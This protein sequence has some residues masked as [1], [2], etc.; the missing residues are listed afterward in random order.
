MGGGGGHNKKEEAMEGKKEAHLKGGRASG[1]SRRRRRRRTRTR[2]RRKTIEREG[3]E[4]HESL[5]SIS[6]TF[7]SV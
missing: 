1:R 7:S 6:S 3:N 5:C 4:N 2:R